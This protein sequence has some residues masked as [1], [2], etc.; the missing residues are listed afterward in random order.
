MLLMQGVAL[1]VANAG[2]RVSASAAGVAL[3]VANAG[4]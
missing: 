4:R 2:R 3:R 1:H